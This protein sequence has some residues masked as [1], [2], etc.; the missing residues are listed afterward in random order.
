MFFDSVLLLLIFNFFPLLFYQSFYDF[1][2][3]F[4]IKF[5]I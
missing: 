4:Q 2:F 1:N 5:M 3:I